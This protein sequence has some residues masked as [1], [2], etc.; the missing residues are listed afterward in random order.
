MTWQKNTY[1]LYFC[2]LTDLIVIILILI[3]HNIH[4]FFKFFFINTRVTCG[5]TQEAYSSSDIDGNYIN[6]G[7]IVDTKLYYQDQLDTL[8]MTECDHVWCPSDN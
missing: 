3:Y 5:L 7:R 2:E 1:D 4:L 8:L 6:S